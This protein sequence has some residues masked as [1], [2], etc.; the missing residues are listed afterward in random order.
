LSLITLGTLIKANFISTFDIFKLSIGPSS[1]HT[2]G[3]MLAGIEFLT[4]IK[5]AS[6]IGQRI[7]VHLYGSLA[8]TGRGHQTDRAIVFGL[9]GLHPSTLDQHQLTRLTKLFETLEPIVF[10]TLP[11]IEFFPHRD[12]LFHKHE[13]L[14][15]HPNGLRFELQS[16]QEVLVSETYFSVGGGFIQT[17][18]EMNAVVSTKSNSAVPFTFGNA[19]ELL[20]LTQD[21]S[22]TIAQIISMNE[23]S[24]RP[25]DLISQ[26]L[27]TLTSA[28]NNCVNRGLTATE[29][30]PGSLKLGRRAS[31]IYKTLS[32][33]DKKKSVEA[34]DWLCVY[35]LA[36]NEENAAGH[37]VVTAPTNGAAGVVPAVLMYLMDHLGY[38]SLESREQF[39]F[40]AGAFG[41]ILK[42]NASISGAEAGCQAE[43]GGAAAMAAAGLCAV[44]GGTPEQIENAAEIALEHHLGLTCDPVH[45][46]VQ[47]PCIERNAFGATKAYLAA[48][49]ALHGDGIHR[50]SFDQCVESL[51]QI[52]DDMSTKYKETSLGGLA[53]NVTSC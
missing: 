3:P 31:P 10:P 45:G 22:L 18:R 39:F 43:I 14:P 40:T 53:V 28:M 48:K 24:L 21:H 27:E 13:W 51:K 23:Q 25:A 41:S 42:R 8:L 29:I 5:D 16:K 11:H 26:Q 1:S 44:L 46:L 2:M 17:K 7:V 15:E 52:G 38:Q 47:I 9:A 30:L 20:K 50:V 49:L 37:Q 19:T 33:P 32:N 36:V 34:S 12:I 4:L 6:A 35:A